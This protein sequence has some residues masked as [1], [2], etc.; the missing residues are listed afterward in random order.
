MRPSIGADY[1]ALAKKLHD[2]GDKGDL[3]ESRA[4]F[5]DKRKPLLANA[6]Q[7]RYMPGSTFKL[8]TT[9]TALKSGVVALGTVFPV[10]K[11]YTPPQTDNPI[12]NY[13]G[14][15][16]GGNLREVFRRSCNIPFARGHERSRQLPDVLREAEALV[17]RGHRE[18]ILT[19][20]NIGQYWQAGADL[21]DVI[22][23]LDLIIAAARELD[24]YKVLCHYSALRG[25]P[26]KSSYS[27][28][29]I[30]SSQT[31]KRSPS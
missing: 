28:S 2:H 11:S 6:Y 20:V 22:R 21:C 19:G 25:S 30:S 13:G 5:A 8:V 10:E 27:S 9:S 26:K 3:M 18:L 12:E 1:E 31:A 17:A 7:E 4:A 29:V 23:Q 24:C 16:C 14:K 15:S